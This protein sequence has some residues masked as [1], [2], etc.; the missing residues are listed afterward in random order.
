MHFCQKLASCSLTYR[1]VTRGQEGTIPRAPNPYGGAKSLR[2]RWMTAEGAEN[3]QQCHKYILQSK[4]LRFEH[5]GG[6]LASCL[7]APSNLVTP[8]LLRQQWQKSRCV[9]AAMLLFHSCFFSH[10]TVQ[11]KC[12][13]SLPLL[14]ITVSQHFQPKMFAFNSH[15]RQ[16]AY[17][18][19]LK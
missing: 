5:G 13:R 14:A 19:N 3:S 6:K 7:R 15:M 18:R 16:N 17:D 8:L 4:D 9:D 11:N 10:C 12:L 2:G 1:G